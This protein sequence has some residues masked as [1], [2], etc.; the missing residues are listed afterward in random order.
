MQDLPKKN[1]QKIRDTGYSYQYHDNSGFKPVSFQCVIESRGIN[2]VVTIKLMLDKFFKRDFNSIIDIEYC[3]GRFP[4]ELTQF[5]PNK[6]IVGI[7]YSEKAIS[8]DCQR[9]FLIATKK[10]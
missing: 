6:R 7:D 10:S 1:K 2:Y 5:F 9:I 3:D 4:S 8:C